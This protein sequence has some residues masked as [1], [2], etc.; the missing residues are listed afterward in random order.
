MIRIF[1]DTPQEYAYIIT[2]IDDEIRLARK[3]GRTRHEFD[4][5]PPGYTPGEDASAAAK[6]AKP[7]RT[8]P[9]TLRKRNPGGR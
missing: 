3:L 8:K 9:V 1:T 2:V 6:K 7:A 4:V 5:C